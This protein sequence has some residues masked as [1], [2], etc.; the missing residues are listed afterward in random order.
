MRLREAIAAVSAIVVTCGLAVAG[1]VSGTGTAAHADL[2]TDA[3][4]SAMVEPLYR[5]RMPFGA[6]ERTVLTSWSNENENA[7]TQYGY[8][9]D[10]VVLYTSHV[11]G[12]GLVPIYCLYKHHVGDRIY[13]FDAAERDSWIAAGY[14]DYGIDFYAS[15]AYAP[16]MLTVYRLVKG[17]YHRYAVG[18]VERD[19]SVA[20]GWVYEKVAFYGRGSFTVQQVTNGDFTGGAASWSAAGAA[21]ATVDGGAMRIDVAAGTTDP[22]RAAV[23]QGARTWR[24][25]K[26]F[27]LSFDAYASAEV[28]VRA[29]VRVSVDP[30]SETFAEDVALT[31]TPQHF[32]YTF[33]T[34]MDTTSY[35]EVAFHLGGQGAFTAYLDNVSLL[36]DDWTMA[37]TPQA[38]E[39]QALDAAAGT[40]QLVEI[41]AERGESREVYATPERGLIATEHPHPV[42]RPV[43]G[44]WLPIFNDL[45]VKNGAVVPYSSATDLKLSNGGTAPLATFTRDGHTLSLTWPDPLPVPTIEPG[46]TAAYAGVLGPDIDLRVKATPEGF[47]HVLVVKTAAAAQDAVRTGADHH[48]SGGRYPGSRRPGHRRGRLRGATAADVGLHTTAGQHDRH[49]AAG[50]GAVGGQR[51]RRRHRRR[52]PGGGAGDRRHRRSP[53]RRLEDLDGVH[54]RVR[55]PDHA[56]HRPGD[57]DRDRHHLPGLRRPDVPHAAELGQPDGRQHRL[58]PQQLQ[59]RPGHGAVPDRPALQRPQLRIPAPQAPVLPHPDRL[60]GR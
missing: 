21:T 9:S 46:G 16:G 32:S 25:G 8:A 20:E 60:D 12:P 30:Y 52:G 18:N 42:R 13:T 31:P 45:H 19:R 50:Q 34:T 17:D 28:T 26:T 47:S 56:L 39:E 59:G 2:D 37:V 11:A 54:Q 51:H 35:G 36:E 57:A 41:L 3:A 43:G 58:P 22:S 24:A 53:R 55:W 29:L 5:A 33:D 49:H 48:G 10:G 23:T 38:T 14:S 1:V 40:G 6:Q 27:T 15:A 4:L 7:V 44:G